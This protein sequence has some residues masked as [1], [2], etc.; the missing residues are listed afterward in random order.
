LSDGER[1]KHNCKKDGAEQDDAFH[2]LMITAP[3]SQ[4]C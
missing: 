1:G 4:G 2:T 3:L